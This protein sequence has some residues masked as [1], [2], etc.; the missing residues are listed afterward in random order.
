MPL[1]RGNLEGTNMNQ[2]YVAE[3]VRVAHPAR[4]RASLRRRPG[5]YLHSLARDAGEL[6]SVALVPIRNAF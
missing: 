4:H 5:A 2:T 3:A 1:S 6:I